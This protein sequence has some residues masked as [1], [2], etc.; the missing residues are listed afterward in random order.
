MKV[1]LSLILL[2]VLWASPSAA[3][4]Q[5]DIELVIAV[6]VSGSMSFDE[7]ETQRRGFLAAF[8]DERLLQAIFSGIRGRIAVTY[9]EWA[10]NG[11]Q[12]VLVPWHVISDHDSAEKFR[13]KLAPIPRSPIRRT[14]IS[15]ALAFASQL[16]DDNGIESF[17]QVIDVSG[18]GPNRHGPDILP[19]RN[20]VL[21]KGIIINGLPIML[22]PAMYRGPDGYGLDQYFRD[23]VIGGPGSFVYPVLKK[24]EL[25]EAIRRKL[26]LE[27]SGQPAR[28]IRANKTLK[29]TTSRVD[30]EMARYDDS[31]W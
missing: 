24:S 29:A 17:R 10:G 28:F 8:A 2:L 5:V 4:R 19:I 14:S 30:C 23:C 16:F 22:S 21:H 12:H 3:Q 13:A 20:A 7:Y 27:I 6:D 25:T 18:D 26:I 1:L 31:D 11:L 15:S 9:I